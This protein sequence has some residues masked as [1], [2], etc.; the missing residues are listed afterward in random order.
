MKH[1]YPNTAGGKFSFSTSFAGLSIICDSTSHLE[2]RDA[3]NFF[4]LL[5]LTGLKSF[6]IYCH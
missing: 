4:F 2:L 5:K 3:L 1:F 6:N